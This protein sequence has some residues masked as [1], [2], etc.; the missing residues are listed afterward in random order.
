MFIFVFPL[1]ITFF[2][3]LEIPESG[4]RRVNS[5]NHVPWQEWQLIS[6]DTDLH[7]KVSLRSLVLNLAPILFHTRMVLD[8]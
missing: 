1:N 4:Q 8:S 6:F 2:L 3:Q 7:A 5:A